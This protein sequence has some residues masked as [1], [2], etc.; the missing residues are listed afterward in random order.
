MY[1]KENR[2]SVMLDNKEALLALKFVFVAQREIIS[3][4]QCK[5]FKEEQLNANI[6]FLG[7][8]NY[9]I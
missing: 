1:V 7:T 8:K 5:K 9:K 6:Y 2:K 4:I 3:F